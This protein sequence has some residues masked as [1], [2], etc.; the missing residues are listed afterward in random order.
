MPLASFTAQL[1]HQF[2]QLADTGC[3][4]GVSL[5]FETAGR[6]DRNPATDGEIAAFGTQTALTERRQ[7]EIF[8]LDDF[9]H[10]RGI[11]YFRDIHS[12]GSQTGD[13]VGL[14]GGESSDGFFR[15]VQ[16]AVR[17]ATYDAGRDFDATTL[18]RA[19]AL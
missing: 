6:V 4:Q 16:I 8:R 3:A 5:G 19:N 9:A 13:L 18:V 15:L 2:V 17:K 10:G 12:V 11:M 14:Q 1:R 7:A